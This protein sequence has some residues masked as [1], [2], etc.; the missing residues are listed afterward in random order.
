[1]VFGRVSEYQLCGSEVWAAS[2]RLCN[3][4]FTLLYKYTQS[5]LERWH[6]YKL[7]QFIPILLYSTYMFVMLFEVFRVLVDM[8]FILLFSS[9]SRAKIISILYHII[10]YSCLKVQLINLRIFHRW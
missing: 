3:G 7:L 8:M 5:T 4:L 6:D 10:E 1:M 2:V 9:K